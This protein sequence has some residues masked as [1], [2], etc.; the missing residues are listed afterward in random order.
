MNLRMYWAEKIQ[1]EFNLIIAK[2][3]AFSSV[4]KITYFPI[5]LHWTFYLEKLFGK[6]HSIFFFFFI[7]KRL[8]LIPLQNPFSC[9][10]KARICLE[11]RD[12]TFEL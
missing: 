5:Q 2:R 11:N 4:L 12:G 6:S 10:Y 3:F 9:C 8:F 7:S 1:Y